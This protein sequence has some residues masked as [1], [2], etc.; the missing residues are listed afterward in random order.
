MLSTIMPVC[1]AH[2]VLKCTH[3]EEGIHRKWNGNIKIFLSGYYTC[4]PS[5]KE[6]DILFFPNRKIINSN[7]KQETSI[8]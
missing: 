5:H 1:I 7:E 3:H 4:T 6:V 2:E 8:G